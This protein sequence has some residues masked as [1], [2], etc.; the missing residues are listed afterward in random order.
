MAPV[1][2]VQDRLRIIPRP[3]APERATPCST[4]GM[5]SRKEPASRYALRH[6]A[7]MLLGG[8]GVDPQTTLG[9]HADIRTTPKIYTHFQEKRVLEAVGRMDGLLGA[10]LELE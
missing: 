7:S 10:V 6:T 2:T 9:G 8:S 1:Q 3:D 5:R 4:A